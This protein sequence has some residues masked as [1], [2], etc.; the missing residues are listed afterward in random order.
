MP[1]LA[2]RA[3]TNTAA[4]HLADHNQIHPKLNAVINVKA[5]FGAVGD[6][7]ADDTAAVQAAI[8]AANGTHL[9][10]PQG[11]YKVAN[12]TEP[13]GAASL[14][15]VG[16]GPELSVIKAAVGATGTLLDLTYAAAVA[17]VRVEGLSFTMQDA[18]NTMIGLRMA[19]CNRSSVYNCNFRYGGIGIEYDMLAGTGPFDFELCNFQNVKSEGIHLTCSAGTGNGTSG[20]IRACIV[21][22][23]DAGVSPISAGVLIDYYTVGIAFDSVQ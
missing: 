5:D 21:Q 7:T 18:V 16:A 6:G 15:I 12:L 23:T 11:T 9:Y 14:H 3:L 17:G 20:T 10:F 4:E 13:V 2:S 1:L 8:N 22:I 19:R